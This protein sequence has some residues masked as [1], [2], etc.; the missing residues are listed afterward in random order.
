MIFFFYGPNTYAA[1]AKLRAM[2]NTYVEKAGSDF[3]LDRIDGTE[4]SADQITSTLQASPFLANSRLVVVKNLGSNKS[5]TEKVLAALDNVPDSTVA[6]FFDGEVDQRTSY[7]KTMTKHPAVKAVKYEKLGLPQLQAWSIKEAQ[8]LG[9]SIDRAAANRL[10]EMVGDDQWRLEQEINKL[11]N[12]DSNVTLENVKNLVEQSNT[13]SI[14]DLVDAMSAGNTKAALTIF[15][16]L[17]ADRTNEV[18]ILT[19]VTWQLR[20]LLLAK[21][22]GGMP[23]NELAKKAGLS[24]YV[25]GKALDKQR[26]FSF[27][28]AIDTDFK[29]KTGQGQPEHLVEQLIYKVA[30]STKESSN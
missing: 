11:V 30:S 29:I 1:S 14:F 25:A 23:S 16:K 10:V 7:F 8:R 5:A 9:G 6:V 24:P 28:E 4:A 26:Q 27:F 18:Y 15:H 12:F 13:E 3:G 2:I 21:T 19:M 20:N 22:S 17:L